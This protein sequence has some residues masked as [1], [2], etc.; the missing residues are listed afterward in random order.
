MGSMSTALIETDHSIESRRERRKREVRERIYDAA[1]ELFLKHGFAATTVEQIA[2]I[3]DVAQTTFFNHFQSKGE[4]LKEMTNEVSA[5]LE[6]IL[7]QQLAKPGTALERIT[8][9][10][11]SV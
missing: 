4:L 10:A 7:A 8:G 2:E 5:R 1:R 11:K 3:A 9:F 6:A